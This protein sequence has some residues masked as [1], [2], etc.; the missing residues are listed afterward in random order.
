MKIEILNYNRVFYSLLAL[1]IIISTVLNYNANVMGPMNVLYEDF[2]SFFKSGFNLNYKFK[3]SN[4]TFPMWGFG[5]ILFIFKSKFNIIFFQQIVTFLTVIFFDKT[6]RNYKLLPNTISF[7]CGLLLSFTLYF[8]HASSYP[9]S[10]GSNLLILGLLFLINFHYRYSKYD[11]LFSG[12]CFGLMLNFRSDYYFFIYPLFILIVINSL[13]KSKKRLFLMSLFWVLI[14]QIFLIPWRFY[15]H[16][17]TG[18]SM[19][20]S[21]NSGHVFFIGLGQLPNNKWGITEEDDDAV[22]YS[23][24]REEFPN[25][26]A[27]SLAFKENKFLLKKFLELIKNDPLEYF[28]KCS[29]NFYRL[30]RTPLYMGNLETLNATKSKDVK[31]TKAKI[32]E[33]LNK[34]EISKLFNFVLYEEG[35]LYIVSGVFNIISIFFYLFF[36]VQFIRFAIKNILV[37]DFLNYLLVLVFSYQI[38]LSIFSFHMP[39]YNMNIYLLYLFASFYFTN[40]L[41]NSLK[42]SHINNQIHS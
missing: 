1:I 28:K 15:T 37:F 18:E 25:Y 3:Y 21:T 38:S 39:I 31:Q 33:H 23:Y 35:K 9:Y 29:Y 41:N 22:M 24:L 17:R 2:N 32:K 42:L 36:L 16:K 6:V 14:I 13:V 40:S 27:N 12:I 10:L 7:R 20:V 34:M 30:V 11:I 4:Y 8:F 19:S 26:K 5:I